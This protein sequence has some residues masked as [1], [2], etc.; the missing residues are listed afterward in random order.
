MR[1]KL[2]S[3]RGGWSGNPLEI[4]IGSSFS[5]AANENERRFF[6]VVQASIKFSDDRAR[7][8]N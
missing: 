6:R 3:R 4:S 5:G 8:I 1:T 2:T 7:E